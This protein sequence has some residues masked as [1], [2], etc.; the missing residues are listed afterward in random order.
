MSCEECAE[1]NTHVFRSGADLVHAVQ[2]AAQ[3]M[4]R[5]V[6]KRLDASELTPAERE[7]MQS[8]M[9]AGASPEAI[10]YR[11]ECTQCADR[12]ALAGDVE[13]GTGSWTREVPVSPEP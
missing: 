11:F 6:L 3:E 9:D 7:A 2:T 10:R 12:F 13:A 5:G 8:V 1:L 4:D